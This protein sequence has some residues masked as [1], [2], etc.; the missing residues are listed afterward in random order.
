MVFGKISPAK[1]VKKQSVCIFL[2]PF[3]SF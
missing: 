1:S 3:V 2:V